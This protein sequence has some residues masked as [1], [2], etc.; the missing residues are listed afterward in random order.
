[1][2]KDCVTLRKEIYISHKLKPFVVDTTNSLKVVNAFEMVPPSKEIFNAFG[3][4]FLR[5]E[6]TFAEQQLKKEL[7]NENDKQKLKEIDPA[8]S[9]ISEDVSVDR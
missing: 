8:E 2:A 6:K 9:A 1:M 3:M 5:A 4:R 7:A